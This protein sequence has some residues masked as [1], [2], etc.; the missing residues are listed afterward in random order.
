MNNGAISNIIEPKT[1]L[2][3]TEQALA[4]INKESG[5]AE[6]VALI[7]QQLGDNIPNKI[8]Y[9]DFRSATQNSL[10]PLEVKINPDGRAVYG[11]DNIGYGSFWDD[12]KKLADV[13]ILENNALTISNRN[14]FGPGS[15]MHGNPDDTLG[16][17]HFLRDVDNPQTLTVTQIQSDA[18]QGGYATMPKTK[19][20]A[21]LNIAQNEKHLKNQ[22]RIWN[23]A[24]QQPDSSWLYPDGSLIPDGIHKQG[25]QGQEAINAMQRAEAKN[26]SQKQLLKKNHQE[27]YLQ[28]VVN[29]AAQRGDLNKIRI[30]TSETAAKIQGYEKHNPMSN[31]FEYSDKYPKELNDLVKNVRGAS[32]DNYD[33]AVKQ[34]N[35]YIKTSN[36]NF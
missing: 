7:R 15:S 28:E 9:N 36:P 16:H 10:I 18:F 13:G 11:L 30:P 29:Y 8:D 21:N 26:L 33:N 23:S 25:V 14:Q 31:N 24:V 32:R 6:K 19:E 12:G 22:K 27:R 5:G 4:I 2:I 34:L 3:N 17:V 1:G 35:N 20:A